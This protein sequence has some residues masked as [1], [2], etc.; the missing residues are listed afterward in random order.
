[1]RPPDVVRMPVRRRQ[2]T[3]VASLPV[4]ISVYASYRKLP[5]MA[6]SDIGN[7]P[8]WLIPTIKGSELSVDRYVS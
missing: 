5:M 4:F 7:C 1:M 3:P 8:F 2:L 6:D